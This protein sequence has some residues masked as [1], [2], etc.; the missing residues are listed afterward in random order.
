MAAPAATQRYAAQTGTV[1]SIGDRPTIRCDVGGAIVQFSY[2]SVKRGRHDG[3][4]IFAVGDRVKFYIDARTTLP[5]A[6]RDLS[7]KQVR[8]LP[9]SGA[10][11]SATS[12]PPPDPAGPA[13]S[14]T[15]APCRSSPDHSA[16]TAAAPCPTAACAAAAPAACFISPGSALCPF[17]ATN[18]GGC[19]AA[20]GAP[21]PYLYGTAPPQ[22]ANASVYPFLP[23]SVP[24]LPSPGSAS[25]SP[26]LPCHLAAVP[27]FMTT[28]A[29][30][31]AS[32]LPPPPPLPAPAAPESPAHT[33]YGAHTAESGS[34]SG[35]CT[36]GTQSGSL[37]QAEA[38]APAGPAVQDRQSSRWQ[39]DPYSFASNKVSTP[40]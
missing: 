28:P 11:S 19:P 7:A 39:H 26:A 36:S 6:V 9:S 17:P 12:S 5:G 18:C 35:S 24:P 37:V 13:A 14:P 27:L 32:Y 40:D 22:L 34:F 4:H 8:I 21:A 3:R 33:L 30:P 38:P 16:G 20:P 2:R 23:T 15:R 1:V 31:A 29:V 10:S 25:G